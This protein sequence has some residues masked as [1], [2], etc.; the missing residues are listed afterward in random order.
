MQVNNVYKC[1]KCG[2]EYRLNNDEGRINVRTNFIEYKGFDLCEKCTR[3]YREMFEIPLRKYG[4]YCNA[5]EKN[6]LLWITGEE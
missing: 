6:A 2:K 3:Y 4:Q 1:D 5:I